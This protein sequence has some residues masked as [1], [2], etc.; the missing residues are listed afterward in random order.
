MGNKDLRIDAYIAKSQDFAKPILEHFR[1][2]VHKACP[3][4]E[5]TI[6]WGFAGLD[7]KSVLVE[8]ETLPGLLLMEKTNGLC[9]ILGVIE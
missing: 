3:D 7:Y 2:L 8:M 4:V 1:E 5:E 6:K 9:P